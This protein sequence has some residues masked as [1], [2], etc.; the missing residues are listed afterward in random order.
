[1]LNPHVGYHRRY[2]ERMLACRSF[3]VVSIALSCQAAA[4]KCLSG[5]DAGPLRSQLKLVWAR[6]QGTSL[7]RTIIN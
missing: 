5:E 1:V 2:A 7:P 6:C 4:Q 3:V